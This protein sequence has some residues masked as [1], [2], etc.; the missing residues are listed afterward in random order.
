MWGAWLRRRGGNQEGVGDE[1]EGGEQEAEERRWAI[2][3]KQ[4][5]VVAWWN[6]ERETE[7]WY[8]MVG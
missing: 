1:G 7:Q 6:S 8:H 5:E 4:G 2:W 3:R